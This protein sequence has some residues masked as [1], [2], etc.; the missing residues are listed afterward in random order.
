MSHGNT[1]GEG[2]AVGRL[3]KRHDE[4]PVGVD[5]DNSFPPGSSVVVVVADGR[6]LD[7]V[8][9]LLRDA[10]RFLERAIDPDDYQVLQDVLVPAV[11]HI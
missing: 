9:R 1:L 4:R 11:V 5:L 2:A 6:H 7:R 10:E 8:R 3:V